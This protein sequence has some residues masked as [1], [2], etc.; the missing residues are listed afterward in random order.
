MCGCYWHDTRRRPA[1]LL[2]DVRV[3][4]MRMGKDETVRWVAGKLRK[5]IGGSFA[6]PRCMLR[7]Y[8]REFER[9]S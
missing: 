3:V 6:L 4:A 8:R 2:R 9:C 7:K 1:N 5:N